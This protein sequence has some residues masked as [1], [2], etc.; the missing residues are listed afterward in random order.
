MHWAACPVHVAINLLSRRPLLAIDSW[1]HQLAPS[2]HT[3]PSVLQYVIRSLRALKHNHTHVL[4]FYLPQLVQLL[5]RDTYGVLAKFLAELSASSALLCHQL[6]WLLESEAFDENDRTSVVVWS[7]ESGWSQDSKHNH[8]RYNPKHGHCGTLVGADPLP[9]L[10]K[11]LLHETRSLLSPAAREY[12]ETECEFFNKVTNISATLTKVKNKERHNAIIRDAM[13]MLGLPSNLYL[14]TNP[15]KA[16]TEIMVESG[17]PMQSAAK[18][19][20]LLVFRTT[21]WAGPD[22]LSE[23]HAD[24]SVL[25]DEPV[26]IPLSVKSAEGGTSLMSSEGSFNATT[27]AAAWASPMR[28]GIGSMDSASFRSPKLFAATTCARESPRDDRS[29][30]R[31]QPPESEKGAAVDGALLDPLGGLVER[32]DSPR[33][34]GVDSTGEGRGGG[35][36]SESEGGSDSGS[37]VI[38]T[39]DCRV[40]VGRPSSGSLRDGM[41]TWK[42]GVSRAW[43]RLKDSANRPTTYRRLGPFRPSLLAKNEPPYPMHMSAAPGED[44]CIFKVYDDCRQDAMT[45]QVCYLP[46]IFA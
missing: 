19:P 26:G 22:S 45:I 14:P 28:R 13:V 39:S 32:I 3:M 23:V 25:L 46:A 1:L 27:T 44:A 15:M 5:R 20:F 31:A 2:L 21:P 34:P 24:D 7:T 16:V 35:V 29:V 37:E 18:C 10:A 40:S 42:R 38:A 9:R 30:V 12:L 6:T 33:P 41:T 17:A 43:A 11:K 4:Q 36:F 8:R